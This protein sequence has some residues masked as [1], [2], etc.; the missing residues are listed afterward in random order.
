MQGAAPQTKGG[1]PEGFGTQGSPQQSALEAQAVPA[2]FGPVTVQSTSGSAVQRGMPRRS[3]LQFK[4]CVWTVPAQQRSVALHEFVARRQIAPAGLQALPLSHRPNVA[5]G[6]FAQTT[7]LD[8]P[9]P[10]TFVEPGE[11]ITP[12]QSASFWQSSPVGRQPLGGWQTR[13]PLPP[14]GAHERLQH[15]PPHI[16]SVPPS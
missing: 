10:E 9:P 5:P 2:G 8:W 16:G 3:C 4:G 6:A 15:S 14:K 12:Q 1:L 11:P 7:S 13:T